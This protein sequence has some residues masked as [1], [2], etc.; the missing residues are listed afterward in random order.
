MIVALLAE[1]AEPAAL[2]EDAGEAADDACGELIGADEVAGA[3]LAVAAALDAALGLED[4][5]EFVVEE[6]LQAAIP[7]D[8]IAVS[9]THRA[10]RVVIMPCSFPR[11]L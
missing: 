6:L 5:A 8:A 7:R 10:V 4:A 11:E 2:P 3:E 9:P 1:M